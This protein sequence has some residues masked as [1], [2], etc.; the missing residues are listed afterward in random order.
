M[1]S[2]STP[3]NTKHLPYTFHISGQFCVLLMLRKNKPR[4][5]L[6]FRTN[7]NHGVKR[8]KRKK[9]R[10]TQ[11]KWRKI[12]RYTLSFFAFRVHFRRFCNKCIVGLRKTGHSWGSLKTTNRYRWYLI[13]S[14]WDFC[15]LSQERLGLLE[16]LENHKRV[17]LAHVKP[18]SS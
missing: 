15:N 3:R 7:A 14:F 13:D 2:R 5:P 12:P 16:A 8:E 1:F 10:E 9:G 17:P 6:S 11:K 18:A 4:N